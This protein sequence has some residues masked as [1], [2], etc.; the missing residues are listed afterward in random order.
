[1][2]VSEILACKTL[3]SWTLRDIMITRHSCCADLT[4]WNLMALFAGCIPTVASF[5]EMGHMDIPDPPNPVPKHTT[6]RLGGGSYACFY[7]KDGA[8]A[9]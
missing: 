1:M 2:F 4:L 7:G 9:L 6:P 8:D 3:K 5:A